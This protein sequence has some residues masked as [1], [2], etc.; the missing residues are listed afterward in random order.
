MRQK[1]GKTRSTSAGS[2]V[3]GTLQ[4]GITGGW[5]LLALPCAAGLRTCHRSHRSRCH[6][7]AQAEAGGATAACHCDK[8]LQHCNRC[9]CCS[10]TLQLAAAGSIW[11]SPTG[12]RCHAQ[13]RAVRRM[14]T[15]RY[16]SP[17]AACISR[18]PPPSCLTPTPLTLADAGR[19]VAA[20]A[21]GAL[22]D[23]E[24]A[25]AA[26]AAQGVRLGVAQTKAART[27]AALAHGESLPAERVQLGEAASGGAACAAGLL[28]LRQGRAAEPWLPCVAPGRRDPPHAAAVVLGR[29]PARIGPGCQ[30]ARAAW[31]G[32]PP[33]R[34]LKRCIAGPV[35][36]GCA[37]AVP[38]ALARSST[39]PPL[40]KHR[41]A[42]RPTHPARPSGCGGSHE[43]AWQG[44]ERPH[45]PAGPWLTRLAQHAVKVGR[46]HGRP[47]T[48]P[49]LHGQRASIG[50]AAG[51]CAHG[52]SHRNPAG[53]FRS[54]R[55][56][57][58]PQEWHACPRRP[59][60][61][62]CS[63]CRALCRWPAAAAQARPWDVAARLLFLAA[64][65]LHWCGTARLFTGRSS[66]A[67]DL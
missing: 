40:S 50:R 39:R 11:S 37:A 65:S 30:A 61:P 2:S 55:H 49:H 32:G 47:A 20:R 13:P 4:P 23:V 3:R 6:G 42:G 22:L 24:G 44:A 45:E 67:A 25:A 28:A 31:P 43:E 38:G 18:T 26:A 51:A 34:A 17:A 12:V 63:R 60:R 14:P 1:G 5:L 7:A 54:P 52:G 64:M 62:A 35:A 57:C 36:H 8:R 16:D 15:P 41:A 27:L 66:C 56:R 9:G 59:N 33:C 10:I 19:G 21:A 46:F 29:S 53:A 48:R 58:R